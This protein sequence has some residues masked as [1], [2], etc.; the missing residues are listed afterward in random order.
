MI[1]GVEVA[2]TLY[3]LYALF[4]GKYT[5][6]KG[7]VVEGQP[8]RIAGLFLALTVPLAFVLGFIMGS[9]LAD[10]GLYFLADV[11]AIVVCGILSTWYARK[12]LPAEASE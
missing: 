11:I 2:L 5:V 9:V 6:G 4:T 10:S 8:A 7:K 1:F 12:N 3:G